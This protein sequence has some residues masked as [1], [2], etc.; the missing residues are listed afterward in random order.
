MTATTPARLTFWGAAGTV[1]GSRFVL[2][3]AD[4]RILIDC[5]LFQGYKTL[6]ERN[7]RPFPVPPASI[8]AV[9]LTHAHL[10]HTGYLPALVRDGF[11]G[12]VHVT[13]GTA[14][15][16]HLLLPDSAYLLEEEARFAAKRGFSRHSPPL[17]LYTTKDAQR[18]LTT[19]VTHPLGSVV[20]PA[21][22]LEVRFVSAG[23]IL[24]ASQLRVTMGG[25]TLH[26]SG[27]LGR[28]DDPLMLSPVPLNSF[29]RTDSLLVESTYGN[30]A[31]PHVD[32]A[33]EL[34]P[35]LD[36]VLTRGGVVIIPA[37]AIGR[38]QTLLLHLSRLRDAGRIPAAPIYL[39]SPMAVSATEL[40]ER[41]P[42]EHRVDATEIARLYDVAHL[43]R[44]V[45][46]SK[47][48]NLR[49]GPMVIVAASG[50]I[51][52]GRVLHHLAAY[53]DD[54]RNAVI[55]TG[56]QAGGTR[57]AAL[58]AG[59]DSLRFFGREHQIR[60]EVVSISSMSAH[61]DADGILAWMRGA[62]IGTAHLVHGEPDAA[63]ALR[64]RIQRELGITASVAEQGETISLG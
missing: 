42:E 38:A 43:V 18:A 35:V 60:A 4:A 50:M 64:G 48:L 19:L 36:R 46:E 13:E 44:D 52:G 41:R 6:R 39:N 5:G 8:D 40:Y 37:F 15:L 21:P 7:R 56:Y 16:L 63:D 27:D 1:T 17:P 33:D 30:R 57:G 9:V 28:T 54:P 59:A 14:E 25:R 62:D 51:T 32:P 26:V 31:H 12:D 45:D 10:D 58:Q 49:G 2:D 29:E 47:L 53:A 11:A 22:G 24:G 61:A 55:L 3:T 20:T 34:Q 23:H